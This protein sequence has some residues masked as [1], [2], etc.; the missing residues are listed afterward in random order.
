MQ[1]WPTNDFLPRDAL[2]SAAQ[3]CYGVVSVCPF[4][5]P[6]VTFLYSIERTRVTRNVTV[7]KHFFKFQKCHKNSY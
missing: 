4:V 1:H 3:L 5:C 2:H 7:L 6:S